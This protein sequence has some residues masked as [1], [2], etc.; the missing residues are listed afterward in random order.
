MEGF[1]KSSGCPCVTTKLALN[2]R[3]STCV[4]GCKVIGF[5]VL[6]VGVVSFELPPE[7]LKNSPSLL[8]MYVLSF[9][10][11]FHDAGIVHLLIH[12]VSPNAVLNLRIV[13]EQQVVL[14]REECRFDNRVLTWDSLD[15]QKASQ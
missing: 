11:R 4:Y 2:S 12:V 9:S 10:E 13:C 14:L 1:D 3:D 5:A 6:P 8:K 7:R 15:I